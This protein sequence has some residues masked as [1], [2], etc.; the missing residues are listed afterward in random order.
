MKMSE[1]REKSKEELAAI[2]REKQLRIDELRFLLRQKKT[3]NVKETAGIRKDI[4][5]IQTIIHSSRAE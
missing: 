1:L 5:R 2:M 4:A 3:K